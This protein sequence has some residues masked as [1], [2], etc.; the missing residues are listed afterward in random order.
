MRPTAATRARAHATRR[1]SSVC[2]VASSCDGGE[3]LSIIHAD[4]R[5]S[6]C[7]DTGRHYACWYTRLQGALDQHSALQ[8][9]GLQDGTLSVRRA[10]V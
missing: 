5:R 6:H 3:Q 9:H 10:R 4:A 7:S 1:T 2:P 8:M